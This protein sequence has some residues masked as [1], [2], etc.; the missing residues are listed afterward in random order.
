M[1]MLDICGFHKRSGF[2]SHLCDGTS[3]AVP[4]HNT[5]Q[6]RTTA[7][8]QKESHFLYTYF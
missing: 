4:F 3:S 6:G 5:T 7:V 2:D 1:K 8:Q